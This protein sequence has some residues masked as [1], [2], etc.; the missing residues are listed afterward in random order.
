VSDSLLDSRQRLQKQREAEDRLPRAVREGP[1]AQDEFRA[2]RQGVDANEQARRTDPYVDHP[3]QAG[4]PPPSALARQ[5]TSR[6]RLAVEDEV[7]GEATQAPPSSRTSLPGPAPSAAPTTTAPLGTRA[8]ARNCSA[9]SRS[10]GQRVAAPGR[11]RPASA[12]TSAPSARQAAGR[13]K[14]WRPRLNPLK[15][16][17]ACVACR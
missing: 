8:P 15:S 11:Q 16:S 10:A 9:R 5:G 3:G 6:E 12:S 4:E 1:L 17:P 13:R 2:R 7:Q 14:D